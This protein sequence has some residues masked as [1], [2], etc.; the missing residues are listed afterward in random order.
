MVPF[1][2]IVHLNESN[3]GSKEWVEAQEDIAFSYSYKNVGVCHAMN[4]M[5][6]LANANYLL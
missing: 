6:T 2:L 4:A 3:D 1:E 5:R